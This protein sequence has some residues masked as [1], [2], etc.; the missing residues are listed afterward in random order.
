[1]KQDLISA[2]GSAASPIPAE[3]MDWPRRNYAWFVASLLSLAYA[4]AILDR[5]SIA[6]LI[7]PLQAALKIDDTDFGLLQGAAFS[8]VYSVLGLPIGMLCDRTRRVSIIV[9]GI[10][11]WSLATIACSLATTFE[12]LFLARMMV[13]VGEAALVPVATSLIAD[14]FAPDIRPKAYGLFLM[15]SALGTGVALA[16]SGLFL[17]WE[18]HIIAG[19]PGIF[20]AMQPWQV[21]FILCG[22][23][24]LVLALAMLVSFR[25]P[26]RRGVAS[27]STKISL[28]P[29]FALLAKSP[30]AFG[31]L[32]LG[33]VL[34]LVCVY[35][36]MGWLPALFIRVHGWT[37]PQ[38]G[39]MMGIVGVPI[40]IVA[41]LFS[42]WAIAWMNR[43]GYLAAPVYAATACALAMMIFATAACFA[44]SGALAITFY[45]LNAI[46]VNW[47]LAAVYSGLT[48]ITPNE[49]RGQIMAFQ[50]IAQGLLALTAGN[51]I[52]GYLS[53][54][55][56]QGPKG[57]AYALATVF[58]VC[59]LAATVIL[60]AG[61][62]A[63]IRAVEAN[64]LK[65]LLAAG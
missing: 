24:G 44:P 26:R 30:L 8:I 32:M 20:G 34:N 59:G 33:T 29:V 46:F 19:I 6:L 58:F 65:E 36:I 17:V 52:V 45:G 5:V 51:F 64:D 12:Q 38:T 50:T 63:Y 25:E 15:G 57:I 7:Q 61:R 40:N 42:G 43:R 56:F 13:G 37:A 47:N 49:M 3:G 9:F 14:Y 1:M 11:L 21:V 60:L 39:W 18:E 48:R 53:D 2:N 4:V 62:K 23:P 55:V 22:A 28:G 27:Q 31:S 16:M 54:T 41:A 35:A 10:A